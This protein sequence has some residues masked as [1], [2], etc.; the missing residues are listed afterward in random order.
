MRGRRVN[1]LDLGLDANFDASMSFIQ[2]TLQ[3]INAGY[4]DPI[5]DIGFV[6]SRDLD[7]VEVSFTAPCSVLH[8]M[9]H[10]G[11]VAEPFFASDDQRLV[12]SIPALAERCQ[13]RGVGIQAAAVIA[14]GCG[15]GTGAWQTAIRDCLQGPITYIGTTAL[16]GWHESTVFCSAFYGALFRNKGRGSTPSAQAA[17]AAERAV[18]AFEQLTGR[19]CPYKV[20]E[21]KPSRQA[22]RLLDGSTGR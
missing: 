22:L 15:T 18:G 19:K 10:S 12:V 5:V 3:N 7:V 2:S 6:R 9:A 8:V 17:D 4:S 21:L 13:D 11:K 1:L 16:I 20:V 14:D